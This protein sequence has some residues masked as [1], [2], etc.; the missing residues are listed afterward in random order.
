V[1]VP[2]PPA[3]QYLGILVVAARQAMRQ[4]ICAR[5]RPFRLT[6]QQFWGLVVVRLWPGITLR[7]LGEAMRLDP[8]SSS[9]L[10]RQLGARRLLEERPDARDRRRLRLHLSARGESLGRRIGAIHEEFQSAMVRGM[11]EGELTTLRAGLR[12]IVENLAAFRSEAVAAEC[13]AEARTEDREDARRA[14]PR[15]RGRTARG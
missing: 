4:A 15:R 10:V 12:R 5:A 13:E 7:E 3:D 9:R 2:F 14:A 8:P 1:S 11:D 6:S